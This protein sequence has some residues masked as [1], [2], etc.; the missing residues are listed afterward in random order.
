[1]VSGA[2]GPSEVSLIEGEEEEN[3]EE[4]EAIESME[5]VLSLDLKESTEPDCLI[6]LSLAILCS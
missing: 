5:S 3:D 6:D 1:M 2:R 4:E